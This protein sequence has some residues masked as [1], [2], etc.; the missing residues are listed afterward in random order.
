MRNVGTADGQLLKSCWF[1]YRT[2]DIENPLDES[3]R[4]V[5]ILRDSKLHFAGRADFPDMFEM[6]PEFDFPSGGVD[7]E[8]LITEAVLRRY[9]GHPPAVMLHHLNRVLTETKR[10][11]YT[12]RLRSEVTSAVDEL[13]ATTVVCC[14]GRTAD[15]L[16]LWK[17]FADQHRGYA[18][19]LDFRNHPWRAK[20]QVMGPNLERKR[21]TIRPIK[22][23]DAVAVVNGDLVI[24]GSSDDWVIDAI[25][26]KL[27]R[28]RDE[29]EGRVGIMRATP[30]RRHFFQKMLKVV[31]L[32][33]QMEPAHEA[34]IIALAMRRCHKPTIFKAAPDSGA[35]KLHFRRVR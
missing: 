6:R 3:N 34:T 11:D 32:G 27:S 16:H 20:V 4:D 30:H 35:G 9:A 23:V 26:S 19:G 18:V 31:V 17:E 13:C 8:R 10:P 28:Y 15:N 2:V 21:L 29:D 7:D 14:F 1:K 5:Q 24:S 25:Y 33:A 12:Q 22:Y